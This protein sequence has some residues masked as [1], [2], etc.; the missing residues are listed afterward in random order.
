MTDDSSDDPV[1]TAWKR[2]KS[3]ATAKPKKTGKKTATTRP[4]AKSAADQIVG[5]TAGGKQKQVP[6]TW[7]FAED[8]TNTGAGKEG[9][10]VQLPEYLV[11]R[12]EAVELARTEMEEGRIPTNGVQLPPTWDDVQFSDNERLGELESRP[13]FGGAVKPCAPYADI[14]LPDSLGVI[15]C[16]IAQYLRSYQVDGVKFL[17]KN[18][19]MQDGCILGDDMGLGKTVQVIAFLTAAFGKT[20]DSRD[21]KRMRKARRAGG[22]KW[23]PRVLVICPS[24]LIANWCAEFRTWGWWEVHVYHGSKEE[25]EMA[26]RAAMGGSAEIVITNYETYRLRHR[27]LNL[28]EWDAVIADECHKIKGEW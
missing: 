23:Y 13:D 18:F 9:E 4:K 17:H 1:V 15:P 2:R 14:P 5:R 3:S 27:E 6:L 22:G 28:V 26:L 8:E 16:S 25:K 12:K 21:A 11:P 20:G 19:V 7:N 10:D 24:S